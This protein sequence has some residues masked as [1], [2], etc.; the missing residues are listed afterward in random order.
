ME[1]L[2]CA[3]DFADVVSKDN[4]LL[5]VGNLFVVD[6][7]DNCVYIIHLLNGRPASS[8]R[9]FAG[10]FVRGLT[11]SNTCMYG[12][13]ISGQVL[14][15]QFSAVTPWRKWNLVGNGWVKSV[16]IG[17]DRN[18]YGV[19][20]DGCLYK[21]C[22]ETMSL[23]ESWEIIRTND[24]Q[25]GLTN[26]SVDVRSGII[27]AIRRT[28]EVKKWNVSENDRSGLIYKQKLSNLS[29]S[30]WD[31][32]IQGQIV[33]ALTVGGGYM[34]V[35]MNGKIFYQEL[36]N[37]PECH[38]QEIR[39]NYPQNVIGSNTEKIDEWVTTAPTNSHASSAQA[40]STGTNNVIRS[41]SEK[42]NDLVT[43][44]S[45]KTNGSSA[46]AFSPW[47]MYRASETNEVW[48]HRCTT[49]KGV[50]WF[51]KNFPDNGWRSFI[52]PRGQGRW[53][54]NSNT[55]DWFI[56]S[57]TL[58]PWTMYKDIETGELWFYRC[59]AEKGEEHFFRKC[60]PDNWQLF[61]DPNGHGRWWLNSK[62]HEWFIESTTYT[63]ASSKQS[64]C[65]PKDE[66]PAFTVM[67]VQTQMTITR[68]TMLETFQ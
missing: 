60:P 11:V 40:L 23:K 10:P 18:L 45:T 54:L 56:E 38:W 30:T 42:I 67:R 8:W 55:Q 47:T 16:A 14:S 65:T 1:A 21:Q 32:A 7:G 2:D 68:S 33:E 27:Y 51:Y 13:S 34:Y 41:N 36:S 19:G 50:E 59:T 37:L 46:L 25:Q 12:V 5:R 66:K 4:K 20:I 52:D 49:E 57:Q 15:Q 35:I 43:T 3:C 17:G 24:S 31:L 62:T 39:Y 29:T 64:M 9:Q 22:I 53:W 44:A 6:S 58:N 63:V 26:I 48:F 28:R 61:I